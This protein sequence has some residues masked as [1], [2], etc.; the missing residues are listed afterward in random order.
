MPLGICWRTTPKD[1]PMATP[2]HIPNIIP[3]WEFGFDVP[4]KVSTSCLAQR[5]AGS[6]SGLPSLS[7]SGV[8]PAALAFL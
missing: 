3:L 5:Y 7:S 8:K 4:D 2:K 6:R 1:V